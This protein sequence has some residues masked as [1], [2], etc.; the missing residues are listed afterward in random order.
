[1]IKDKVLRRIL[2]VEDNPGDATLIEAFIHD[3]METVGIR[4]AETFRET[5]A[6]LDNEQEY[7]DVVLLDLS[8]PDKSAMELIEAIL[9]HSRL[10]CPV[11]VLTGYGDVSF[12]IRSINIGI[13]DYLLKDELNAPILYKSII[14]AIE[15]WKA[16]LRIEDSEKKYSQLF[17]LSPQPMWV[18]DVESLKFI[19]VNNAALTHYGYSK[20]EFLQM[21][22]YDLRRETDREMTAK[23][24]VRAHSF[25]NRMFSGVFR[26]LKKSGE[27]IDVE[28]YSTPVEIN[29]RRCRSVIAIDITEKT[30]LE[31][32]ITN[33]IIKTQEDERYEIGGELHDN[34][35]QILAAAQMSLGNVAKEVSSATRPSFHQSMEYIRMAL[36]EIRNLSHRL[37]PAFFDD[38]NL[39]DSISQLIES[40][41]PDKRYDVSIQF[42]KRVLDCDLRQDLQLN[43]YRIMQEQL[44]NIVK[45]SGAS[46]I[47]VA[48]K[49]RSR[50][51]QM[52]IRDNGVGFNVQQMRDGIGLANIRRRVELFSGDFDVM[53]APGQGC[54]LSIDIPVEYI[55]NNPDFF[56]AND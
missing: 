32:R 6:I 52:Q 47:E 17:N 43:L 16:N 8:L 21:N 23:A 12:G 41:N 26:H 38:T 4:V 1:M 30:K 10:C 19:Q 20:E 24:F 9:G 28:I 36:D 48:V 22:L 33:A 5:A 18:Y 51:M 46:A 42:D 49:I 35:C 39:E 37:A 56:G 40:I 15:R 25:P 29:N 53:S 34:V 14:Y 3:Q 31:L 2:V 54:T 13:S 7:Y 44:N 27:Q 55:C 50:V 45:H 11:I